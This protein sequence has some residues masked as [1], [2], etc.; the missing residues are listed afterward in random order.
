MFIRITGKNGWCID[1]CNR[2]IGTI[3]LSARYSLTNKKGYGFN[4]WKKYYFF[5]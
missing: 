1:G 2:T 5:G 3:L 4:Q